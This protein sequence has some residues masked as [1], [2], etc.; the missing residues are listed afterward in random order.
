MKSFTA[1]VVV[2]QLKNEILRFAQDEVKG[3]RLLV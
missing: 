1:N 3:G 2:F